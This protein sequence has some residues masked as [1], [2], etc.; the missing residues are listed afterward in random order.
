MNRDCLKQLRLLPGD[1]EVRTEAPG[2]APATL[3][4]RL[5]VGQKFSMEMNLDGFSWAEP[6]TDRTRLDGG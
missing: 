4:V 5:E 2:F 1:Y 3:T 6:N